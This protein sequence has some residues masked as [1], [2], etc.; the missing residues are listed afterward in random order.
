M[1]A[2]TKAHGNGDADGPARTPLLLLATALLLA[3]CVT[4]Q[5]PADSQ[6]AAG[7]GSNVQGG[8][9]ENTGMTPNPRPIS[10]AQSGAATFGGPGTGKVS[11]TI[12]SVTP[13]WPR[14]ELRIDSSDSATT[15]TATGASD[16]LKAGD[17]LQISVTSGNFKSGDQ[18]RFIDLKAG[19]A[20]TS[21]TPYG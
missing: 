12:V 5:P 8:G 9:Q 10:I 19:Q 6:P 14:A 2:T 7:S 18:L 3:G 13:N 1:K 21:Y 16:P 15:L 17:S 11:V 20:S 4:T